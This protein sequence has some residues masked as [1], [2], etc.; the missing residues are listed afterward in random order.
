MHL[1][2]Y[3][4]SKELLLTRYQFIYSKMFIGGLNW[5]TTDRAY[6]FATQNPDID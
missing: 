5:E 4:I 2:V 6:I 1:P 3:A